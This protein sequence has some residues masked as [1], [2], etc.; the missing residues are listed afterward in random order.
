MISSAFSRCFQ[1]TSRSRPGSDYWI[2]SKDGRIEEF[3][4]HS[5]RFSKPLAGA[6]MGRAVAHCYMLAI[7][8]DDERRHG[9]SIFSLMARIHTGGRCAGGGAEREFDV[10]TVTERVRA[11]VCG[12]FAGLVDV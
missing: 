1:F 12:F 9:V 6:G 10:D 3:A 7:E 11:A 4:K 5:Q 8:L 2:I